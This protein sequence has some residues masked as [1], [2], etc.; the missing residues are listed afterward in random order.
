M[1]KCLFVS[2][3]DLIFVLNVSEVRKKNFT[4]KNKN[5]KINPLLKIELDQN[6]IININ[7]QEE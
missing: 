2:K 6:Q 1:R 7:S 4:Y 5:I 3:D